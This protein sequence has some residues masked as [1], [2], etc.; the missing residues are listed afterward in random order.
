MISKMKRPDEGGARLAIVFNGS[1][2]AIR[3]ARR[4]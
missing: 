4:Q 2:L 1:P 3:H